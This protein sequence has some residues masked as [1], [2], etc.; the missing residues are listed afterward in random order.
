MHGGPMLSPTIRLLKFFLVKLTLSL[1]TLAAFRQRT[2]NAFSR[3][4]QTAP[5]ASPF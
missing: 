4:C 5:L 3:F 2:E 1:S